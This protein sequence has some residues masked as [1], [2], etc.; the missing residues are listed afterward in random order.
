MQSSGGEALGHRC[1]NC[2]SVKYRY[3]PVHGGRTVRVDCADCGRTTFPIWRKKPVYGKLGE[4]FPAA[5]LAVPEKK[6]EA[7]RLTAAALAWLVSKPTT[8]SATIKSASPSHLH[9]KTKKGLDQS[10][11]VLGVNPVVIPPFLPVDAGPLVLTVKDHVLHTF[12]GAVAV[13]DSLM[14]AI[15]LPFRQSDAWTIA[16]VAGGETTFHVP[17]FKPVIL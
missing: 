4:E 5:K 7:L 10:V 11:V 15:P 1:P 9:A 3:S 16:S 14:W 12:F 8:A 2:G 13:N 17:K 6:A